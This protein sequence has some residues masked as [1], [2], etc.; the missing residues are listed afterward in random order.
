MDTAGGT[1]PRTGTLDTTPNTATQ[2]T[3]TVAGITNTNNVLLGTFT[4]PAGTTKT[5][6]ILAGYWDFNVYFSS[7][8]STGIS[9]YCSAYYVDSDGTS[10][11][12]TI[13]LGTQA[14]ATQVASASE[15]VYTYSLLVPYTVLPDTTKRIQIEVRGNFTGNNRTCAIQFRNGTISHVHT[16]LAA[17]PG[18]GATGPT[19]PMG[20]TGATGATG[21]TG[22]TGGYPTLKYAQTLGSKQTGVNTNGATIVSQSFTATG[23]PIFISVTGDF[24]NGML[25]AWAQLQLYRTNTAIGNRVHVEASAGSENAPYCLQYIDTPSAGSYTYSLKANT[26]AGGPVNFGETDGPTIIVMELANTL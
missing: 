3:I 20:S 18:V 9:F 16:T 10:N 4:E 24:E 2:T 25:T 8:T 11:K 5:P 19:G 22:P 26:I 15:G 14:T 23:K 7:A 21:A 17:N 13:Q 12:T 1:Y 6:I